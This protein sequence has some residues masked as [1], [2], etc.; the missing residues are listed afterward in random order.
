MSELPPTP[1]DDSYDAAGVS[2]RAFL[3]ASVGLVAAGCSSTT[4]LGRALPGPAWDARHAPLYRSPEPVTPTESPSTIMAGVLPRS[5]WATG[6]PIPSRMNTMLPVTYI[7]VHHDGMS[8]F[9]GNSTSAGAR[10]IDA[11]RI[12]HQ[13]QGWGDI[14]YHFAIDRAGNIWEGRP[15]TYQGA[16]V[17]DH[18]EH[19]IGVVMLGNFDEQ[20]PTNAQVE[21]LNRH[22]KNLKAAYGVSTPRLKT[23]QEWAATACPGRN[24]QAYMVA[25]RR[26]GGAFA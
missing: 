3:L 8:P 12:A 14:G 4:R 1:A 22:V 2:R 25:A 5:K 13:R 18:N 6:Q 9:T 17:K 21:A 26:T 19:N 16:H 23:H 10:R 11:I 15:L 24:V 7:T 20:R